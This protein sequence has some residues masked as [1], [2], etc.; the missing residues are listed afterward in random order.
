[1]AKQ[2]KDLNIGKN[3]GI[4]SDK[5]WEVKMNPTPEGNDKP[6]GAFLPKQ[7]K[8]RPCMHTKVNEC[9]H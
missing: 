8:N 2:F 9:D 5:H 4:N 7:P 1:M 3:L 6:I